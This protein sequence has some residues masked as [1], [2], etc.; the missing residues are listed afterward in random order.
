MNISRAC[1]CVAGVNRPLH[2]WPV[3]VLE[4]NG[5]VSCRSGGGTF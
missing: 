3:E 2:S 5:I 1:L 4:I